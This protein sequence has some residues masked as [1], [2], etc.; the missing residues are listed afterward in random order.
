MRVKTL[1]TSVVFAGIILLALYDVTFV[2]DFGG[3]HT[4]PA[5]DPVSESL[6]EN[7]FRENDEALHADAFGT[8]DNPDVQRE[9]ISAG[10]QRIRRQCRDEFPQRLIDV[11]QQS[12]FNLIDLEARFW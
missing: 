1:V 7:C 2:L 11:E 3:V 4:V 6:Y 12:E 5:P 9:V 8:I 10:R